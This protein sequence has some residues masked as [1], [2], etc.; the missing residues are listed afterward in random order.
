MRKIVAGNWKMHK[1]RDEAQALVAALKNV[2]IPTGVEVVVAPPF[3]FLAQTVEQVRGT[4]I[5]VAAQ[6]CHQK[7]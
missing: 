2:T 6:N 3:P 5:L 4:A 1:D 7:S